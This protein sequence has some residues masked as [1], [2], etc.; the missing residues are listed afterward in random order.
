MDFSL[1]WFNVNVGFMT[2]I[3]A[4]V[5]LLIGIISACLSIWSIRITQQGLRLQY[6][7]ELVIK[8]GQRGSIFFLLIENIGLGTAYQIKYNQ[9]FIDFIREWSDQKSEM[10]GN[11]II[12]SLSLRALRSGQSKEYSVTPKPMRENPGTLKVEVKISYTDIFKKFEGETDT[13]VVLF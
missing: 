4:M 7:P 3:A 5:A 11:D 13:L 8:T 10:I 1:E 2:F 6:Q 12:D 9:E